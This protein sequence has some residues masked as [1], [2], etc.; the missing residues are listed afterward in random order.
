MLGYQLGYGIA[1]QPKPADEL[2]AQYQKNIPHSDLS[3]LR[4]FYIIGL[5][6][7]LQNSFR[8]I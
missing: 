3:S 6:A 8:L 2:L 1:T 5:L 4:S 7:N